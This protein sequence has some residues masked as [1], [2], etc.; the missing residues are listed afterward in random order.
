MMYSISQT[1]IP[2]NHFTYE[3]SH[4]PGIL[5]NMRWGDPD[6]N[7]PTQV[8]SYQIT[9]EIQTKTTI[10]YLFIPTG[11]TMIERQMMTSIGETVELWETQT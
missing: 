5:P 8:R 10:R 6:T 2:E 7:H 9:G 1:Y 11:M 3:V 4:R